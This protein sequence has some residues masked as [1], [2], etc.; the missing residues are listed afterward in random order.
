MRLSA[1][2]AGQGAAQS[3]QGF[4]LVSAGFYAFNL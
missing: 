3:F 2:G 4:H 1:L